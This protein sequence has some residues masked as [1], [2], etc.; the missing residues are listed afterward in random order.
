MKLE[1][2]IEDVTDGKGTNAAFGKRKRRR[3]FGSLYCPK[4]IKGAYGKGKR[5]LKREL[6]LRRRKPVK[7]RKT[8][9]R[10]K[11]TKRKKTVKRRKPVKEE[12][13]LKEEKEVFLILFLV[14]LMSLIQIVLVKFY[15]KILILWKKFQI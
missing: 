3:R 12:L 6:L 15:K 4:A 13:L 10:R 7:R 9:K 8:V 2:D 5:N 14:F 11:P 1:E